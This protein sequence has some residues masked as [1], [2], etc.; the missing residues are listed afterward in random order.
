MMAEAVLNV[1]IGWTELSLLL[2]AALVI[3]VRGVFVLGVL[4]SSLVLAFR[5]AAPKKRPGALSRRASPRGGAT[6]P[7]P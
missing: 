4:L 7:A 5:P 2:G 1:G 3:A 6:K